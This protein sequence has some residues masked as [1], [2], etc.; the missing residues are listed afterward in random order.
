MGSA[1]KSS[2]LQMSDDQGMEMATD[3]DKLQEEFMDDYSISDGGFGDDD[4][5]DNYFNNQDEDEDSEYERW[6]DEDQSE[7]EERVEGQAASGFDY[8]FGKN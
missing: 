7:S 8:G 5:N 3:L 1:L 4:Y 6:R 2:L